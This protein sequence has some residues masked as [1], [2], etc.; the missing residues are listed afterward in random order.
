MSFTYGSYANLPYMNCLPTMVTN[1]GGDTQVCT[2]PYESYQ[3]F[4]MWLNPIAQ[5]MYNGG[6]YTNPYVSVDWAGIYQ[7]GID[8]ANRSTASVMNSRASQVINSCKATINMTKQRLNAMLLEDG[9]T[10]E[11][12]EKIN[13]LLERLDEQEEKLNELTTATDL[14]PGDAYKK[15]NEIEKELRTIIN[16][17]S[18]VKSTS[19]DDDD[20][21]AGDDAGDD[22]RVDDD[23]S[24]GPADRTTT[25]PGTTTN[26]DKFS[27]QIVDLVDKFHDATYCWGTDDNDFNTVCE[28]ITKDNVM[29][30][31]LAWN[32]YH[33]AEQ[34]ESFM[35]A[36]MWDADAGQK[37]KY[38]KL[39][40]RALRSKAE[41]LGV[42]DELRDEFA[43]IDK[44]MG[45]WLWINNNIA[46]KY[47]TII[48][49]IAEKMG[50]KYGSPQKSDSSSSS[51][52]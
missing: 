34:G 36:F 7:S 26:A 37:K 47:D 18:K 21:D 41:E 50:S 29:D 40:A 25:D 16:D 38:G 11:Q 9:I 27:S 12:K 52:D 8:L 33:S 3:P 46:D 14:T 31:M 51:D 44:E 42:Y 23:G 13:R 2:I 28:A 1:F 24:G 20:D 43:A 10:D 49:K 17:I 6:M 35:E 39:I 15:A 48:K 30:I 5:T 19:S 45:S 4:Y 22:A 32:K